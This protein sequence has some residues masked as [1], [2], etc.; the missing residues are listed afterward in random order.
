[1]FLQCLRAMGRDD[2]AMQYF[3]KLLAADKKVK[4]KPEEKETEEKETEEKPKKRKKEYTVTSAEA[5]LIRAAV[6]KA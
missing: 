4:D 5:K 1:M 3:E 6:S 2:L